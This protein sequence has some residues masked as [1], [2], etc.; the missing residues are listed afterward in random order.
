MVE[1]MGSAF[2][3]YCEKIFCAINEIGMI[4]Y[5]SVLISQNGSEV[6]NHQK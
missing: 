4:S 2:Y 5:D 3:V 6:K 1:I